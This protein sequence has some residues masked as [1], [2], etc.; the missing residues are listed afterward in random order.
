MSILKYEKVKICGC[1]M[2]KNENTNKNILQR[3][4]NCDCENCINSQEFP[5]SYLTCIEVHFL[6]FLSHDINYINIIIESLRK[7]YKRKLRLFILY[8]L[9]I[10]KIL[11]LY[12]K[13]KDRPK[14]SSC[15]CII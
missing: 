3:I 1:D 7:E 4:L 13:I 9:F 5:K 12:K 6:Y 11:R 14:K 15:F 10:G 2:C 8:T